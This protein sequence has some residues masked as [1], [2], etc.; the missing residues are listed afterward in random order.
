M[1]TEDK[2]QS[3][4]KTNETFEPRFPIE[5]SKAGDSFGKTYFGYL[6]TSL[7]SWRLT[8]ITG[9]SSMQLR[10]CD[11]LP[12]FGSSAHLVKGRYTSSSF[13]FTQLPCLLTTV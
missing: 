1:Y 6:M 9:A 10:S 12:K 3:I 2:M 5:M 11:L 13:M 8:H 7:L 4:E